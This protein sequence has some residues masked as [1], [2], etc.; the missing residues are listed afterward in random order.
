MDKGGRQHQELRQDVAN[1]FDTLASYVKERIRRVLQEGAQCF[2]AEAFSK[3]EE[4]RQRVE[5]LQEIL[6]KLEDLRRELGGTDEPTSPRKRL[7][8]GKGTPQPVFFQPI[9]ETLVDLGG[10][11]QVREIL[12]GVRGRMDGVL[13]EVDYEPLPSKGEPRWETVACFARLAMVHQGMLKKGSP[14]GTWEI[15]EKGRAL[16]R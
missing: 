12:S 8:R 5:S 7:S 4:A 3:A 14:R 11:G 6:K 15:T 16:V 2:E 1:A 9:L 13:R 10:S